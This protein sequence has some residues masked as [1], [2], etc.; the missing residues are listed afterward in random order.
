[1]AI[2][3]QT[4]LR[5]HKLTV[6]DYHR[7]GEAGILNEDARVELI[8]GE[9]LDM[10]PIG[11]LHAGTVKYLNKV[12]NAAVGERAIVS[13]Q[14][15]VFLDLH[16]ELQLDLVL[17]KPRADFYR[18]AHPAFQNVLLLIEVADTSI[19]YNREIKIPLYARH[20]IPEVWLVDVG[21]RRLTVFCSPSTQGYREERPEPNLHRVVPLLLPEVTRG[22]PQSLP[23]LPLGESYL[24][25]LPRRLK[26]PC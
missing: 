2:T 5:R 3:V 21:N 24:G 20:G 15:P 22:Y 12:L 25:L 14:D 16:S 18:S 7:M 10:P 23:T 4:S 8:E 1:M 13:A 19:S 11:S 26:D 17:L 6:A 9:I